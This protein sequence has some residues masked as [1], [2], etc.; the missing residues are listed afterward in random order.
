MAAEFDNAT[1][2]I[3]S[4]AG[5]V[6]GLDGNGGSTPPGDARTTVFERSK[7]AKE[8]NPADIIDNPN[9]AIV[10]VT[11][12]VRPGV[13]RD[14]MVDVVVTLPEGSKVKSLRGG[15]LQT[16]PL[17]TFASQGEV[18]DYLKQNEFNVTSEGNKLLR[19]HD[20]A[21]ARGP[22]QTALT[23]KGDESA[24]SDEPL[25]KGFDWGRR[26][27]SRSTPMRRR[28]ASSPIWLSRSRGQ[29]RRMIRSPNHGTN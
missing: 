14:E 2:M 10:I 21:L 7:V 28:S 24:A 15:I 18:R 1:D 13:R 20:V 16:T 12:I 22:I 25:K 11:A 4:G 29:A 8:E 27:N 23:G 9:N 17:C 5:I 26:R 6:T 3:V 19:G